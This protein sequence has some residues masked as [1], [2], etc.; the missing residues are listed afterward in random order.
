MNRVPLLLALLLLASCRDE[1][2]APGRA[3]LPSPA[4]LDEHSREHV[5]PAR[6]EAHGDNIWVA[7]GYDLANTTLIR[8]AA[9]NVVV[10]PSMSPER[11]R[12]VRAAL[13]EHSPGPT[14]ALIFTHSHIDHVATLPMWI[15]ACLS[16]GRAPVRRTH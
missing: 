4:L 16:Q 9:G 7:A 2:E 12:E 3:P 11:A 15:E 10:D 1:V 5:G 8:T 6:V 14:L 13:L